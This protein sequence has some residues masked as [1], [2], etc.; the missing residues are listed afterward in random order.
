M[1]AEI[2]FSDGRHSRIFCSKQTGLLVL[3]LALKDGVVTVEEGDVV[4]EQ[5]AKSPLPT[6][7]NKIDVLLESIQDDLDSDEDDEESEDEE[8]KRSSWGTC[9]SAEIVQNN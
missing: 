4:E 8:N 7:R 6:N 2:I 5:L 9:P 1:C 3:Y